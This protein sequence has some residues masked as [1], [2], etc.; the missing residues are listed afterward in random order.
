M[1]NGNV[2]V[3]ITLIKRFI[4]EECEGKLSALTTFDFKKL[5]GNKTYGCRGRSFDCDDTNLARAIYAVVW[6]DD[7]PEILDFNTKDRVLVRGDT[8]N[9]FHTLF[10]RLITTDEDQKQFKGVEHYSPDAELRGK[11]SNFHSLYHTI[12]NFFPLP[13]KNGGTS[14][15][16]T[17][18]TYRGGAK[19]G[20]Y[21]DLFLRQLESYF[22]DCPGCDPTITRLI[23]LN[24]FYFNRFERSKQG[25]MEFCEVNFLEG[26]L[27]EE[28]SVRTDLTSHFRWWWKRRSTE[29]SYKMEASFYIEFS[30]GLIGRRADIIINILEQKLNMS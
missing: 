21:F 2:D 22:L 8:L 18:N 20:D 25:F 26:Y 4:D 14:R 7:F 23:E 30:S 5:R 15:A 17:L 16:K 6:G 13:N 29:E 11:V 28:G 10:G 24:R 12:G 27:N 9:T 19:Y 3:S 1:N